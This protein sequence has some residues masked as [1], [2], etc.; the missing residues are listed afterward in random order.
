MTAAVR[1]CQVVVV[2]LAAWAVPAVATAHG[3]NNDAGM[4]HACIGNIS[5]VVRAVGVGGACI[6]SPPLLAETAAHWPQTPASGTPGPKGEKGDP[7]SPGAN[8]IDGTSVTF[9][10]TFSGQANGCANG[11]AIFAVGAVNAY[12][13]N[14]QDATTAVS[15]PDGPCVDFLNRYVD[16]GNGTVTDTFTGLIWLKQADCLGEG[17]WVSAHQA[18]AGLKVG[19]CGLTDGSSAGDWRL[20]TKEEWSATVAIAVS[21]GCTGPE[22]PSLTNDA[23]ND[24]LKRGTSS[25]VAVPMF[26]HWASTS[27]DPGTNGTQGAWAETL[28]I[29]QLYLD[30]KFL[31]NSVWAVRG[32][33]R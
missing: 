15:R 11:G 26:G 27:S 33:S 10:G 25:F 24:C 32:G 5:K 19:A 28:A 21:L 16:C 22:A 29:G 1:S 6:T 7:G 14:G 12:V 2:A 3:G 18:V 31:H 30:A 20:P 9:A 8:G 13:C 4:V 17:N 23:G